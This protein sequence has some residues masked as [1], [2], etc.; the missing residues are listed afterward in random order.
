LH[1]STGGCHAFDLATPG[2]VIEAVAGDKCASIT[3]LADAKALQG[4]PD[5]YVRDSRRVPIPQVSA[6]GEPD[7][8]QV[9]RASLCETVAFFYAFGGD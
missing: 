2:S 1:R 3:V 9:P 7:L 5:L 8:A 6:T 4:V